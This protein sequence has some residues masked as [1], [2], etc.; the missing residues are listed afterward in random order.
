MLKPRLVS[1]LL[2][3]VGL[4]AVGLVYAYPFLW[5][6]A[7]SLKGRAD[8]FAH[9]LRLLPSQ[10]VWNNYAEA[11]RTA[12]FDVYLRNSALVTVTATLITLVLTSMAGYAL[13][14][15]DFPGKRVV[16]VTVVL[17]LFLPK[18]YTIIPIFDL[19]RR[20]GL[21]NTLWSV[22]LVEAA[23]GMVVNTFLFTGYFGTLPYE[24]E[25]AARID[26]AGP[27]TLYWRI[28]LPLA[29]PMIGTVALFEFI[30]NWNSFLIPLVFT[31]G[32]PELRTVGVAIYAFGGQ[33]STNWTLLCAAATLS[34]LP[35]MLLFFLLQRFF[36]E[37]VAGAIRG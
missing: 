27:L 29:R 36:V 5:M 25:E 7:G 1:R 8:L 17:T 26:G 14:R 21:L 9:G 37:G 15:S 33:S 31:L 20:L 23:M 34:L 24:L 18:G 4:V 6:V 12:G 16:L 30:G 10:L 11:W 13:A 32:K 19:V 3:G 35:T 2:F 22:I 28:A